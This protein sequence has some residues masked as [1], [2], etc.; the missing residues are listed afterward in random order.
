MTQSANAPQDTQTP[1]VVDV[2]QTLLRSD[3][4]LESFWTALGKD[5][6]AALK[7][8]Y[9]NIGSRARLKHELAQL[10]DLDVGRVPV[11]E[12]VLERVRQAQS[13]GR[14][15][16]LASGSDRKLVHRVAA[17]FGIEGQH[18]GSTPERNLTGSTKSAALIDRFGVNGFDYIGDAPI[19]LKVWKDARQAVA[20]APSPAI[21]K[22]LETIGK[23]PEILPG[24]WR[25]KHLAKALRPHQWVKNV[26]LLLPFIASHPKG[27]VGLDL[28]LF[29]MISFSFA[30]SSIY[31]VN[32][33]LDLDAD[34]QHEKKHTRPFAAGTVPIRIG[35]LVSLGLGLTALLISILISWKMFGIIAI[36]MSLSLAYSIKLKS[37]RWVDIWVLGTLYTLR[38]VAGAVAASVAASGWLIAFVFPVFMSLGCVK[39]LTE[40]ARAKSRRRVPGRAYAKRDRVDLLNMSV[41]AALFANIIFLTYTYSETA[42]ELYAGIWELRWV[43]IPITAWMVRMIS[44]GWAG[45]QDYDPIV[46][47]VRDRTGLILSI[48]VVLGLFNAAAWTQ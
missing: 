14:E 42:Y 3:L 21:L 33:L 17:R 30:A 18:I 35:M 25:F 22:G 11:N 45:S 44:T 37:M 41:M 31:V 27:I 5:A 47:A 13:E 20:V 10:S 16:V 36:Y 38:V 40:V 8:V 39:R 2:D 19:D 43:V 28:V 9:R 29:A 46:F 32:D 4:L 6:W 1:L 34:R 48:I 26:L 12:A 24:G 23:T 15:V 7:T